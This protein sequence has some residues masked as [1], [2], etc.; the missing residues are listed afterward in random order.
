MAL[1][2]ATASINLLFKWREHWMQRCAADWAVLTTTRLHFSKRRVKW[3]QSDIRD[4][5]WNSRSCW[6]TLRRHRTGYQRR[7]WSCRSNTCWSRPPP[8]QPSPRWLDVQ[9]PRF[10]LRSAP[11][12]VSHLFIEQQ[13]WKHTKVQQRLVLTSLLLEGSVDAINSCSSSFLHF[14]VVHWTAA[15]WY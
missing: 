14:K 3:D 5:R 9:S 11:F 10:P 13:M 7:T 2:Y 4:T 12:Q 6:G 8:P 1:I 15:L